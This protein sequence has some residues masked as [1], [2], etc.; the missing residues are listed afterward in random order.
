M[1]FS[2]AEPGAS[3][4]HSSVD[5]VRRHDAGRRWEGD[6]LTIFPLLKAYYV[7][8][9]ATTKLML[10]L[11]RHYWYLSWRKHFFYFKYSKL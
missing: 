4:Q 3:I 2:W 6:L 7:L 11:H 8:R 5:S 9:F 1:N 10:G